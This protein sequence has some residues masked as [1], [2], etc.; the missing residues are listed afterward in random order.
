M[1]V[2]QTRQLIINC[3]HTQEQ[4]I[5]PRHFNK[6]FIYIVRIYNYSYL[7]C[8]SAIPLVNS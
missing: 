4:N 2:S 7:V 1:D 8:L 3:M 5:F 6:Y